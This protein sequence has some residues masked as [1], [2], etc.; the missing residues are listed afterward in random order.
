MIETLDLNDPINN[1]YLALNGQGQGLVYKF[2]DIEDY[3][4]YMKELVDA[5]N[6]QVKREAKKTAT[7]IS[8]SPEFF[9][10]Y[11]TKIQNEAKNQTLEEPLMVDLIQ[12]I[13][14]GDI[15]TDGLTETQYNFLF[16]GSD[17]NDL[18]T[19]LDSLSLP[20]LQPVSRQL[21][22]LKPFLTETKKDDRF[23]K[24]Y[25]ISKIYQPLTKPKAFK[26]GWHKVT[27]VHGTSNLS[28]VKILS[29]GFKRA[30]ELRKENATFQYMGSAFGD[31]I[32]FAR[33]DQ[34]SKNINYLD[35][36]VKAVNY[37]IVADL[38]YKTIEEVSD[39]YDDHTY[40]GSNLVWA[41][42]IGRYERDEL[43]VA[44]E[45]IDI[46]YIIEIKPR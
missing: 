14:T 39:N 24:A 31:G 16:G 19:F 11:T 6:I 25:R 2:K 21:A 42:L 44:P 46:K 4:S 41:K 27:A 33:P 36:S 32:Y 8:Q 5:N 18:S 38:Y 1:L 17:S 15:S 43:I 7:A 9:K 45:Q 37:I 13:K 35:R 40:D 12:R 10:N 3:I 26:Q 22:E 23:N 29:E 34:I 30:S 28:L 20:V